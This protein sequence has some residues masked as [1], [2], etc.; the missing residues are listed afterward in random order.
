MIKRIIKNKN[1]K[2]NAMFIGNKI[3]VVSDEKWY[4]YCDEILNDLMI[5]NKE[6]FKRLKEM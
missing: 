2:Y 1:F 6:V 5:E 4:L 3:G